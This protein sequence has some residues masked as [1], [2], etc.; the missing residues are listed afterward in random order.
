MDSSL[1]GCGY[2]ALC[3]AG[4]QPMLASPVALH[5]PHHPLV[6][7]QGRCLDIEVLRFESDDILTG[8]FPQI[9]STRLDH[10]SQ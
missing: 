9:L 6:D 7:G 2:S 3:E 4:A 10:C 5:F 8:N 1:E